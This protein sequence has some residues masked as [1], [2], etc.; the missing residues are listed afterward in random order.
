MR[1][2]YKEGQRDPASENYPFRALRLQAFRVQGFGGL[3]L[4]F[5]GGFRAVSWIQIWG[6][7]RCQASFSRALMV[8]NSGYFGVH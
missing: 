5:R 8:L 4:G 3:N 2:R 6:S 1:R 7:E